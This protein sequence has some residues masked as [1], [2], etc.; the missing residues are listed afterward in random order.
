MTPSP[1]SSSAGS[2]ARPRGSLLALCLIPL[3]S[4]GPLSCAQ[5]PLSQRADPPA[6]ILEAIT[7]Q[8]LPGRAETPPSRQA[9]IALIWNLPSPPT[10]VQLYDK[11]H[12]IQ[13][14]LYAARRRQSPNSPG[15][16]D[17][18]QDVRAYELFAPPGPLRASDTLGLYV[19]YTQSARPA[20]S[21][22]PSDLCLFFL[23]EGGGWEILPL[24]SMKKGP[25]QVMP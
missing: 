5:K 6:R 13:A 2:R 24:D 7:W 3:L 8:L 9:Q 10:E 1:S 12:W 16:V 17:A 15:P 18:F 20:A 22:P 21:R 4:L 23:K 19:D 25:D 14:D 11:G